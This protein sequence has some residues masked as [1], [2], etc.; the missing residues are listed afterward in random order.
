M[1]LRLESCCYRCSECGRTVCADLF[2]SPGEQAGICADCM[3]AG[4]VQEVTC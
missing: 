4:T 2:P 3:D 1:M